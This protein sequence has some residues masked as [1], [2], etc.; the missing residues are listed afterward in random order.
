MNN[1]DKSQPKFIV[2]DE[3]NQFKT[4]SAYIDKIADTIFKVGRKENVH[5]FL[6]TQNIT[7][8]NPSFFN[9]CGRLL[10]FKP[11]SA[12]QLNVLGEIIDEKVENLRPLITNIG[13]VQGEYSEFLVFNSDDARSKNFYRLRLSKFEY[14]AFIT[15]SPEDR[16]RRNEILKENG[17]DFKAAV[18]QM[19][20]ENEKKRAR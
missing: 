11:A 6:I 17:N 18:Y 4:R 15:T 3:Y 5:L 7:D 14:Y 20:A 9:V 2:I 12:D 1:P 8:F 16:T 19:V 13:T 10:S